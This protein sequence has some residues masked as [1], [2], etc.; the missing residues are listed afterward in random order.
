MRKI[1]FNDYDPN[2]LMWKYKGKINRGF[3]YRNKVSVPHGFYAVV[4]QYNENFTT[5][6]EGYTVDFREVSDI[7]FVRKHIETQTWGVIDIICIDPE[8]KSKTLTSILGKVKFSVLNPK[9]LVYNISGLGTE[10]SIPYFWIEELLPHVRPKI[11]GILSQH[12]VE[13]KFE[14]ISR[15][16]ELEENLSVVSQIFNKYGLFIESFIPTD[17]K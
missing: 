4:K 2:L 12:V 15:E 6:F 16:L 13:K 17:M 10:V 7:Y 11:K 8:S 1:Y 5:V 3:I 9:E 14:I